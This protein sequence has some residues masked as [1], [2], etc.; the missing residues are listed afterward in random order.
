VPVP[1]G[2][3]QQGSAATIAPFT[4]GY[5]DSGVERVVLPADTEA[6]DPLAALDRLVALTTGRPVR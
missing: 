2:R 5:A 1:G 3:G 4:E 6:S